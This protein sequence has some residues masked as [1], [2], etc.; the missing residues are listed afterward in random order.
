MAPLVP[1]V[2]S[3]NPIIDSLMETIETDEYRLINRYW[4]GTPPDISEF[5]VDQFARFMLNPNE[6]MDVL[7]TI[8]NHA[9]DYWG[10]N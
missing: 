4:E 2:E 9:T 8:E 1:G 5:A 3:N 7:E 6:Y 10:S